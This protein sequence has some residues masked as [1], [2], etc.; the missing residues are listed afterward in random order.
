MGAVVL[1]RTTIHPRRPNMISE[2]SITI[3]PVY[4]RP[5]LLLASSLVLIV[6]SHL[7]KEIRVIKCRFMESIIAPRCAAMSGGTHIRFQN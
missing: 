6:Y 3:G 2:I 4:F 7:G 5:E 1:S